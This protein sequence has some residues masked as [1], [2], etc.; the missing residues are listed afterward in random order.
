VRSVSASRAG[1]PLPV[2]RWVRGDG[3]VCLVFCIDLSFRTKVRTGCPR[4]GRPSLERAIHEARCALTWAKRSDLSP[5]NDAY[6]ALI[7]NRETGYR[8]ILRRGSVTVEFR[9][10]PCS[11]TSRLS[12]RTQLR[13]PTW[14]QG[15]EHCPPRLLWTCWRA[16][17]PLGV[18]IVRSNVGERCVPSQMG[19]GWMSFSSTTSLCAVLM[20]QTRPGVPNNAANPNFSGLV[21]VGDSHRE[22]GRWM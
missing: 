6:V 20:Q 7:T 9:L 10:R 17:Y 21:C 18:A 16:A 14:Q 12:P 4:S 8:W 22:L 11:P 3:L 5:G 13:S 2:S 15:R 19:H 1:R